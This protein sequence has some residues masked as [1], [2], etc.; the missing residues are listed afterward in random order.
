[1]NITSSITTTAAT[2]RTMNITSTINTTT[3][4]TVTITTT[5]TP[6]PPLPHFPPP[7]VL[8]VL[9]SL[10]SGSDGV[11]VAHI[12]N[13]LLLCLFYK[14]T[15]ADGVLLLLYVCYFHLIFF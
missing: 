13:A 6:S 11:T 1:M 15:E 12:N 2:T 4:A 14:E 10:F 5:T 3:T 8:K 9:S 7:Q